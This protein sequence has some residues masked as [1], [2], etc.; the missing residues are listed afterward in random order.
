MTDIDRKTAPT[1]QARSNPDGLLENAATSIPAAGAMSPSRRRALYGGVAA[2]AAAAGAGWAWWRFQPHAVEGAADEADAAFFNKVFDAP[3][4]EP[5]QAR[6]FAGKP[7]LLNFWATWCPPCIAELP[8]LSGFF[9]QHQG[10]SWQVVGLAVDQPSSVRKFLARAPVAF[11]IG[12]AGLEGTELSRSLGN[13]TGGL[14]FTVVFGADGRVRARK[15][16][17]L[18]AEDL[19]QWV[20]DVS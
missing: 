2:A 7:L 10:Q 19:V 11:P 5:L 15:M 6:Q 8:M 14:P 1:A 18:K 17:Q 20:S 9:T 12:M 13:L 3:D 16:G 4:G